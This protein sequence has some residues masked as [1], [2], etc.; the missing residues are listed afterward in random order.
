MWPLTRLWGGIPAKTIKKRWPA[1]TIKAVLKSEWWE[2][3]P[4]ALHGIYDPDPEVMLKNLKTL[5][6]E[7][8]R[9][10]YNYHKIT[11]AE[12]AAKEAADVARI[13][14]NKASAER[15]SI[16]PEAADLSDVK[17]QLVPGSYR[18]DITLSR[19][20]EEDG[21]MWLIC[22]GDTVLQRRILT[23][24]DKA[25]FV[26][27][28]LPEV[29]GPVTMRVQDA[30]EETYN[31]ATDKVLLSEVDFQDINA[32]FNFTDETVVACIASYPARR[33]LLHQAIA[34]LIHQVDH[35]CVY[36]NAYRDVPDYIL[37][38]AA[39]GKLSYIVSSENSLR[40]AGKFYW[41]D[42][43]GYFL[44]CDDDILY[45]ADYALTMRTHIDGLGRRSVVGLM[46]VLFKKN[47]KG[48]TVR[49]GYTA[50]NAAHDET[51]RTH[52]LGT[53]VMALHSDA[54]EQMDIDL[55]LSRPI[56]ND[57]VFAVE[58]QR[59]GVPLWNIARAAGWV[60][61]NLDMR[62]GIREEVA[63]NPLKNKDRIA[64]LSSVPVWPELDPAPVTA[65][66]PNATA[67]EAFE[68]AVGTL[69]KRSEVPLV[70]L[71]IGA[72]DGSQ[73]DP[74]IGLVRAH[75]LHG[76]FFEPVR[77]LFTALQ[78]TYADQPDCV[79]VNMAVTEKTGSAEIRL[80]DPEAI[81]RGD[82]PDWSVGLGT[83]KQDSNAIDGAGGVA[84][85]TVAAIAKHTITEKI[86]TLSFGALAQWYGKDSVDVL[87]TDAEGYDAFF[88]EQI[89]TGVMRPKII[90]SEIMV[91]E[92]DHVT[93]LR[94]GLINCGYIVICSREHLFATLVPDA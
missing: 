83:L 51:R 80:V 91:L 71:Q 92:K 66:I 8:D 37:D 84:L 33:E 27:F 9:Y 10:A 20:V 36:L 6:P 63:L 15:I 73:F 45:P 22:C 78:Q 17:Q 65:F 29:D 35:V 3:D 44:L 89:A 88:L 18:A 31:I 64:L 61:P 59:C 72:C 74:L 5:D 14:R 62:Y 26:F 38:W 1:K 23:R 68:K 85:E 93:E 2:Y 54:L 70:A 24:G 30:T 53:G 46:G 77:H 57:E 7:K 41:L 4:V 40:A 47:E 16:T 34:S 81:A 19:P 43:P 32:R 50:F 79:F 12:V 67:L 39:E 76:T 52:L 49:D 11:A 69:A 58:A 75:N 82:V 42:Q 25:K 13:A 28:R 21:L 94:N 48:Y 90:L 60:K 87:V 86:S 56:D 55:L